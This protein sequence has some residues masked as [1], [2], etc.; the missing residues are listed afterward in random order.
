MN[1][2]VQETGAGSKGIGLFGGTFDPVHHGHLRAGEE[3]RQTFSLAW[4]EYLPARVP[5]HK[6]DRSITDVSHR[7]AMLRMAVEGNPCFRVSEVEANREGPSYLVDTLKA[8]RDHYPPD[9]SLYFIMGMDSFQEIATWHRYADLFFLSH[10]IVI[11][12]PGY[13]RPELSEVVSGEVASSFAGA[14]EGKDRLEHVSGHRIHFC[15]TTR[16]DIAGRRIRAWIREERSVR[17][18]IPEPVRAYVEEN[19]LYTNARKD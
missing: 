11:T 10:F 2:P 12:R 5:P 18:L 3:I 19:G 7:I 14:G 17:Y 15:E 6:T 13:P 9:V 1:S 4:V 16:L 8:Y